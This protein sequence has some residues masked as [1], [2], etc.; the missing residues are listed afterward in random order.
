MAF[1]AADMLVHPALRHG[2]EVRLRA[3]MLT[4]I[5]SGL[6]LLGVAML[7]VSPRTLPVA[8]LPLVQCG[9]QLNLGLCALLFILLRAMG[10]YAL[11]A[12]GTLLL[13]IWSAV[14]TVLFTGGLPHSPAFG[15]LIA[16]V[17]LGFSLGGLRTGLLVAALL[18][19]LAL[20]EQGIQLAG[21]PLPPFSATAEEYREMQQATHW[22]TYAISS[23]AMLSAA[24]LRR[25]LRRER[26]AE[27][28]QWQYQ[29]THDP[30]TGLANRRAFQE[31]L[32]EACLRSDRNGR[33]LALLYIDL[34]NFKPINDLLGHSAGDQLL[35][36]LA[37]RLIQSSRRTDIVARLGGDEF[38]VIAEFTPGRENAAQ[39]A[40][41]LLAALASPVRLPLPDG[42]EHTIQIEASLGTA[43]YPQEATSPEALLAAADQAMYCVKSL[44]HDTTPGPRLEPAP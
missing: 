8:L 10:R 22:I 36:E 9:L 1:P 35:Q 42:R 13:G 38:A 32:A 18:P 37:R 29:A 28:L 23:L 25:A 43:V 14:I 33:P 19:L 39:L 24:L 20:L 3:L 16:P 41:K 27:R 15:I 5:L 11:A 7:F 26:D 6:F 17:V 2:A 40:E 12:A 4:L 44:H 31:Q 34:D 30:L 21:L